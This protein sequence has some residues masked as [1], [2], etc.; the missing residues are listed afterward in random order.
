M[1]DGNNSFVFYRSFAEALRNLECEIDG[2]AFKSV[3]FAL[4]DYAL[5]GVEP[6]LSGGVERAI[7]ALMRPQ[8]DAN[9]GRRE[10]A[11]LGGRPKS[12]VTAEE[13]REK[14]AELGNWQ[15]VADFYRMSRR[16][17]FYALG[18]ADG[19]DEV[20]GEKPQGATECK[21]CK[22][23]KPRV[24]NEC[25]GVQVQKPNANANANVNA[26]ANEGGEAGKP[27]APP[28]RFQ[29]P[30]PEEVDGFEIY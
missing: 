4:L 20:Q 21:E 8:I 13:L 25:N 5:D 14:H 18:D 26:N 30:A 28:K 27:P 7:F 17:V 29:K 3:L 6:E 23:Q 19:C 1:T 24:Q 12:D 9:N 10:A 2:G 11:K 15:D 22:V 16:A